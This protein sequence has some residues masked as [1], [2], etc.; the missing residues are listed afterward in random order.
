M[1]DSGQEYMVFPSGRRS[2]WTSQ[3]LKNK[4]MCGRIIFKN[5]KK[6]R[7]ME[8]MGGMFNSMIPVLFCAYIA[9]NVESAFHSFMCSLLFRELVRRVRQLDRITR[10][11]SDMLKAVLYVQPRS[12]GEQ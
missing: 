7:T 1:C 6:W 10:K 9:H 3:L 8:G 11:D 12:P 5:N 4:G 2:R